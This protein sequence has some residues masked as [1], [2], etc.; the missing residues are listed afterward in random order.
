MRASYAYW[1]NPDSCGDA[2]GEGP[3]IFDVRRQ[4]H[5]AAG[6]GRGGSHNRVDRGCYTRHPG[7]ALKARSHTS[8]GLIEGHDLKL[9]Q[10]L[11]NPRV[12]FVADKGLSQHNC[13]HKNRGACLS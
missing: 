5:A 10:G 4:D 2:V 1:P 13:W 3:D 8:N 12:T 9:L 7:E 11:V 6:G